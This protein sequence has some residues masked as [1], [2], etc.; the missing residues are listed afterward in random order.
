MPLPRFGNITSP[1]AMEHLVKRLGNVRAFQM[2]SE[3]DSHSHSAVNWLPSC[4]EAPTPRPPLCRA[5]TAPESTSR[6]FPIVEDAYATDSEK[7]NV[8]TSQEEI[9]VYANRGLSLIVDDR[10]PSD[11]SQSWTPVA[12]TDDDN[13]LMLTEARVPMYHPRVSQLK[14]EAP[15]PSANSPLSLTH[16]LISS[17]AGPARSHP[18]SPLSISPSRSPDPETDDTLPSFPSFPGRPRRDFC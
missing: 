10:S 18:S 15:S 8:H 12:E 4:D 11:I 14:N 7:E 6:A 3:A 5:K 9:L 16:P 1:G 13:C 2:M 17:A